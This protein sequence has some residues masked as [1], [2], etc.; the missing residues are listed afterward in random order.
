MDRTQAIEA[1]KK[2]V[3]EEN[4]I[5]PED[6]KVFDLEAQK[7]EHVWTHRGIQSICDSPTH[8]RHV[9]WARQPM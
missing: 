2:A 5:K 4:Y 8:P 9:A 3:A 6:V 1:H 7:V